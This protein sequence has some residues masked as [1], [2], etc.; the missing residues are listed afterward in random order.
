MTSEERAQ[1]KART[2]RAMQRQE[3]AIKMLLAAGY[4]RKYA[5]KR[6]IMWHPTPLQE[7]IAERRKEKASK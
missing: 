7:N 2:K 4:S 1:Q 3:E 5:A 6:A